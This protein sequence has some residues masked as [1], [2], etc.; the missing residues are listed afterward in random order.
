MRRGVRILLIVVGGLAVAVAAGIWLGRDLPRRQVE[1]GLAGKLEA[2]VSLGRLEILG[3]RHFVLYDLTVTRMA[4]QP[5]VGR[6]RVARLEAVG[7]PFEMLEGRFDSLAISGL[8]VRLNPPPPGPWPEP[9]GPAAEVTVGTLTLDGGTVTVA[10]ADGEATFT[11]VATFE[12]IGGELRGELRAGS[13]GF[14]LEPLLALAGANAAQPASAEVTAFEITAVVADA[15]RAADLEVRAGGVRARV[16]GDAVDLGGAELLA[17]I[18]QPADGEP[19]RVEATARLPLFEQARAA[20]WVDPASFTLVDL[21]A[22]LIGLELGSAHALVPPDLLPDLGGPLVLAGTADLELQGPGLDELRYRLMVRVE[23]LE[24]PVPD[25]LLLARDMGLN[26]EGALRLAE[27][28]RGATVLARLGVPTLEGSYAGFAV[29]SAV[30]P[31]ELAFEGAAGASDALHAEGT[32][33]LRTAGTGTVE[34]RGTISMASGAPAADFGWSWS[35]ASLARLSGVALELGFD[36]TEYADLD[37]PFEASGTF[38]GA[39][40]SPRLQVELRLPALEAAS[41]EQ[42]PASDV[43][44]LP[45]WALRHAQATA[46]IT[47]PSPGTPISLDSLSLEGAAW[48]DPLPPV[49]FTLT[50]R[51]RGDLARRSAHLERL[52]LAAPGLVRLEAG[53]TGSLDAEPMAT[54][55]V[56]LSQLDVARWQAFLRP[57]IGDPAP[58]FSAQGT[59]VADLT[60]ALRRDGRWSGTGHATI[61]GSGFASEDGSRVL[62]GLDT[63]WD[64]RL[65]GEGAASGSLTGSATVAGFQVLWDSF[66]ADG[67]ELTSQLEMT[68]TASLGSAPSDPSWRTG[69]RVVW[70]LPEGPR[71]DAQIQAGAAGPVEYIL[72]VED[73]DLGPTV[74]RYLRAPLGHTVPFFNRIESGGRLRARVAG[75]LAG[76][77]VTASGVLQLEDV[78]IEGTEGVVGALGLDLDFPFDLVLGPGGAGDARPISGEPRIGR[79]QFDALELGGLLVPATETGLRVVADSLALEEPLAI[80]LLGGAIGFEELVLE[81]LLRPTRRLRSG[82]L[83]AGIELG[84]AARAFDVVPL[85]GRL[86]GYLPEVVV[87]PDLLDVRGG[88]EIAVFGGMVRFGDISGEDILTRFPKLSFS[89]E[90]EEIDLLRVTH[91]FDF[92]EMSGIVEGH[93]HDCELFRWVPTRFDAELRTVRRPGVRR[94]INVKAINNL[95]ILGTGGRI[96]IFDRGIHKFLDTYTYDALGIRMNLN[97]DVFLLRGLERRGTRELFLKGRFPF[98]IDIVNVQPGRSVSFRSMLDR[99]Q[100][101]DISAATTRP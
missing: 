5:R 4:G 32:L 65:E 21:D 52:E 67:S 90:F 19:Y 8:D 63:E 58:G 38:R 49:P 12:G 72:H 36:F 75:R 47:W 87:S 57:L 71:F 73:A 27:G 10:A 7:S 53:G 37:G 96:T 56:H 46:R 2:R 85:E 94:S 9:S 40:A 31:L 62:E 98:P 84:E 16:G 69:G 13:D 68:A 86:D 50:A 33:A 44:G 35:G 81:D 91:T 43:S 41:P 45:A 48:V 1:S 64:L 14:A 66:Y 34:A 70:T 74:E 77:A 89:V 11:V 20:A 101:L 99:L 59:A 18:R 28:E 92:G 80:S 6:I 55:V 54:A 100:S 78:R 22:A 61:R 95:A 83:V 30:L 97:N 82:I 76:D 60:G 79:V 42:P 24:A 93:L 23:R 3:L 88:G 39:L 26:A 51:G 17:E 25:G 29:P 15:G